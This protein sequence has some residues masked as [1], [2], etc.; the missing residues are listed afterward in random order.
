MCS[1]PHLHNQCCFQSHNVIKYICAAL[2]HLCLMQ[3]LCQLLRLPLEEF[4]GS[5][6]TYTDNNMASLSFAK[7]LR[8]QLPAVSVPK[9]LHKLRSFRQH[10]R[11]FLFSRK[12]A[13]TLAN[14]SRDVDILDKGYKLQRASPYLKAS[15]ICETLSSCIIK[16]G[17]A[18]D[19]DF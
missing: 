19:T 17:Y 2:L 16:K 18:R 6:L 5:F 14:W 12:Q 9:Y 7:C 13:N 10:T 1:I 11:H 3:T 15:S 4:S 8:L